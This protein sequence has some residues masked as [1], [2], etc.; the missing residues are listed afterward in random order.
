MRHVLIVLAVVALA[1]VAVNGAVAYPVQGRVAH[2]TISAHDYLT[3]VRHAAF[4]S[5]TAMLGAFAVGAFACA[6]AI[7]YRQ[8]GWTALLVGA[9]LVSAYFWPVLG[10]IYAAQQQRFSLVIL[11]PAPLAQVTLDAL[12]MSAPAV[13][14]LLFAVASSR[15][16]RPLVMQRE[17]PEL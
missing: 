16:G 17:E 6:L 4:L 11:R 8:P 14:A 12:R 2:G 13:G 10:E 1:V 3:Y 15:Q 7:Q 5:T 9:L